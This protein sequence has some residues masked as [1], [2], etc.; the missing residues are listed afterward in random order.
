MPVRIESEI[1]PLRRV[2]VH[3]PGAEIVRMTQRDLE[4]ALFDD[5]LSPPE[6]QR[7][8]D[9]MVEIL[10]GS[11][12]EVLEIIDLLAAALDR[13]PLAERETL[14]RNLAE[15]AGAPTLPEVLIAWEPAALAN[16]LVAGI[17]WEDVAA[18]RMTLGRIRDLAFAPDRMAMR[19]L[20]NLMFM[21]DPCMAVQDALVVGRMATRAR[22]R[23]P[24]L[25]SFALRHS[26]VVE[27]PRLLFAEDDEHRHRSFRSIEGGDVLVLSPEVLLVGCSERTSAPTIERL[28]QEALFPTCP[29]LSRIYVVMLPEARSV[30]HLDTVLTQVDRTLFL[31]HRRL[32]AGQGTSA[33]C[34]VARVDRPGVP[35]LL[36]GATVLDV[37]RDELGPDTTLVP[38][39]GE[40]P[41]HQEREQ[42]T[43]GAN[44]VCLAPG[45]IILYARNV[46][47][48]AALR[49]HGFSELR[50][51][52]VQPVE[53]RAG[54]LAQGM[55]S[56]R[57]VFSFSGSELSR[58]RGGGR[59]LT[60]PIERGPV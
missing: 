40:D 4:L 53:D 24:Y 51:H 55:A 48:I 12:A 31:G 5:I 15:T 21:R 58:A 34:P 37:L 33:P 1:G 30:M 32:M 45:R 20:P 19:P 36:R 8:H 16:A 42:W 11:G 41:L 26:G 7:E 54:L 17:Y 29:R 47:T 44:A 23:E 35:T 9:M 46:H 14:L 22:V 13:A 56:A 27:T 6:T 49:E 43:D 52:V 38:C 28:A 25:V 59:C 57:T 50:L 60:M 3:R 10:R 2:I 18:A 39:G